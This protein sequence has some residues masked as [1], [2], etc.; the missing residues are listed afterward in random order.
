[1]YHRIL[2]ISDESKNAVTTKLLWVW[3]TK[4][5]L[6]FVQGVIE[7]YN[8][9]GIISIGCGTGLLE[10]LIHSFSNFSVIGIEV[11]KEWWTSKYSMPQFIPVKFPSMPIQ[12]NDL[13]E[14]HALLFCY[15]NNGPAFQ[16][17]VNAYAGNVIMIIGPGP[18]RGTHTDPD[19]FKPKLKDAWELCDFQEVGDTKDFIAVYAKIKL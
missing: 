14:D 18:G 7:K 6:Q 12:S 9:K 4:K 1:M 17:Y 3:P 2:D 5:N 16:D 13:K 15:F 10:W 11:N 19:P 8:L